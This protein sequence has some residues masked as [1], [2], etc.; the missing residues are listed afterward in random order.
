MPLSLEA[1]I[2]QRLRG[3]AVYLTEVQALDIRL[4]HTW[5]YQANPD[6]M[7]CRPWQQ[8]SLEEWQQ[9]FEQLSNSPEA[10]TFAVRRLEDDRLVGRVRYFDFNSRNR[11]VEIGYLIGQTFRQRGYAKEALQ[12]MLAYLFEELN[13][14]KVMAQTGEFNS[15]SIA[16]LSNLGFQ[17]DGCLRQHHSING[18][19]YNDLLFSLLV[20]DFITHHR[21]H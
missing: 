5:F 21:L 15:P 10:F 17:R 14:N 9:R 6:L 8:Q 11:A 1:S 13:V 4:L 3:R 7:T 20:S 2:L 16:L 19:F 12:L 18:V